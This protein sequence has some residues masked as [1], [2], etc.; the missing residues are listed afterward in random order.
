M[1]V[2]SGSNRSSQFSK[3]E[4]GFFEDALGGRANKKHILL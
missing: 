1:K 2:I 3:I 4:V